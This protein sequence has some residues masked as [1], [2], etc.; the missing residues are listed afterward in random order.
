MQD[1][2]SFQGY[3]LPWSKTG[4]RSH[5]TVAGAIWF[6]QLAVLLPPLRMLICLRAC[7]MNEAMFVRVKVEC[8]QL[9]CL[10]CARTP[11]YAELYKGCCCSSQADKGGWLEL[12][13]YA[14]HLTFL[15]RCAISAC[16]WLPNLVPLAIHNKRPAAEV[17][18]Y[19]HAIPFPGTA[20]LARHEHP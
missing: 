10:H 17:A 5:T 9:Q 14:Q 15:T 4:Q 11:L 6:W 2:I 3:T 16:V 19:Y 12:K 7:P 20:M 1:I 13:D 18:L 8:N